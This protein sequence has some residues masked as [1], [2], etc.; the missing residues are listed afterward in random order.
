M[1]Q[2]E[3]PEVIREM[4]SLLSSFAV[5]SSTVDPFQR[6]FELGLQSGL[7]RNQLAIANW[8]RVSIGASIAAS[9]CLVMTVGMLIFSSLSDRSI[10]RDS[11]A[12][13]HDTLDNSRESIESTAGSKTQTTTEP[14][15]NQASIAADAKNSRDGSRGNNRKENQK[16]IRE[17]SNLF[18]GMFLDGNNRQ[19]SQGELAEPIQQIS[20]GSKTF[21]QEPTFRNIML[22]QFP[23][24]QVKM[25]QALDSL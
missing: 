6:A 19:L 18:I 3:D 22:E 12:R 7:A 2:S 14:N 15:G 23:S 21:R 24:Y 10:N 20:L 11:A 9:L 5:R 13:I 4:E 1:D 17:R 16:E 8:K 25:Q